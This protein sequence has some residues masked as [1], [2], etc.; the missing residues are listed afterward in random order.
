MTSKK[1]PGAGFETESAAPASPSAGKS[2][3]GRIAVTVAVLMLVIGGIAWVVQFLPGKQRVVPP[4]PPDQELLR[5]PE[6]KA[7]WDPKD[8]EYAFEVERDDRGSYDYYFENAYPG[9]VQLGLESTSCDCSDVKVGLLASTELLSRWQKLETRRRNGERDAVFSDNDLTWLPLDKIKGVT[10]PAQGTGLLRVGWHARKPEGNQLRLK[11][12]VWSY[13]DDHATQRRWLYVDMLTRVVPR[14]GFNTGKVSLGTL[15]GGKATAEAIAWS[16]TRSKLNLQVTN[17]DPL[18]AWTVTPLS[19]Q[20]TPVL[21]ASLRKGGLNTRVRSAA[22]LRLTVAEEKGGKVLDQGPFQRRPT[23]TLDGETVQDGLPLFQGR[24]QGDI[25]IGG[26]DESGKI[27]L[28][29]FPVSDGVRQKLFLWADRKIALEVDARHPAFLE[30][31]LAESSEESSAKEKKWILEVVVPR[32]SPP[33][34][35]ADD[36]AILLRTDAVPPRRVRIPIQ[37]TAVPG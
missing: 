21:E 5:F 11:V 26:L 37:G 9:S 10:V 31:K 8:E 3:S 36:S 12:G 6:V 22:A 4:P 20:S 29:S 25:R 24:V 1:F 13:P 27:Q 17:D 19:K 16:A 28:K 33:G 2:N 7:V 23:I 32:G 35:F 18:C 34:P 30:A 14:L 15:S